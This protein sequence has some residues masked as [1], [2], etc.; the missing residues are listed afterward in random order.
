MFIL[1]LVHGV[2]TMTGVTIAVN[3]TTVTAHQDMF[4]IL[5]QILADQ[6]LEMNNAVVMVELGI[7]TP[8]VANGITDIAVLINIGME[9]VA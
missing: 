5:G 9:T 4:G 2:T 6:T 3:V 1:S 8:T 7:H